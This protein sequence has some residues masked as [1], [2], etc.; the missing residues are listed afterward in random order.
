MYKPVILAII[1]MLLAIPLYAGDE[2]TAPKKN[3]H[4]IPFASEG[5]VVELTVANSSAR[6]VS[7][8]TVTA[9]VPSWVQLSHTDSSI[10]GIG[11]NGETLA[12]FTFS[13]GK[14]APVGDGSRVASG[15]YVYQIH[16]VDRE[17]SKNIERRRMLLLK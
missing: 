15:V 14:T 1:T 5:N 9:D 2:S 17:G 7:G 13:V 11:P 12:R 10:D 4:L 8:V 6:A 3:V 16:A